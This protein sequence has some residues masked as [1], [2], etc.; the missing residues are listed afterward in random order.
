MS[1]T[2]NS[3]NVTLNISHP[4]SLDDDKSH[5]WHLMSR[6]VTGFTPGGFAPLVSGDNSFFVPHLCNCRRWIERVQGEL[7]QLRDLPNVVRSSHESCGSCVARVR[8]VSR[9]MQVS[10]SPWLCRRQSNSSGSSGSSD[11]GERDSGMVVPDTT[12]AVAR[13]GVGN[14]QWTGIT[15]VE[16]VRHGEVRH[17]SQVRHVA[18]VTRETLEPQAAQLEALRLLAR[19]LEAQTRRMRSPTRRVLPASVGG[20][21]V[22]TERR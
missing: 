2:L 13:A 14:H 20:I 3:S 15:S 21:R 6:D 4:I 9:V 10:L 5:R 22:L 16:N 8:H 19:A 11:P 12:E 1:P 7:V 18:H 17:V